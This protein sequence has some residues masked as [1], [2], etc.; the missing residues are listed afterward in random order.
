MEE[1]NEAIAWR[2]EI[3][4]FGQWQMLALILDQANKENLKYEVPKKSTVGAK[5]SNNFAPNFSK[6]SGPILIFQTVNNY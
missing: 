5:R 3:C 1:C 2:Q 6:S 4:K